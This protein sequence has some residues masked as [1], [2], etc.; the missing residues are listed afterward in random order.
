MQPA[1]VLADLLHG[2]EARQAQPALP[3]PHR[4][5]PDRRVRK[6]H[7]IVGRRLGQRW[8]KTTAGYANLANRYL[9]DVVA[10]VGS[11]IAVAM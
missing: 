1:C 10:R 4:C 3:L 8:N 11:T 9:V 7:S 5:K 6:N 2:C